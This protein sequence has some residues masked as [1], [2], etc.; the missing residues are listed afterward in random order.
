[1]SNKKLR[2][3]TQK[4]QQR[5]K[6]NKADKEIVLTEP[7]IITNEEKEL[8][9]YGGK[10]YAVG[11][12]V[13]VG[14][15]PYL[16]K[17]KKQY[18]KKTKKSLIP[19]NDDLPADDQN[20]GNDDEGDD[21]NKWQGEYGAEDVAEDL[22]EDENEVGSDEE[23]DEVINPP[24][25]KPKRKKAVR[26]RDIIFEEKKVDILEGEALA[27][28][29][30]MGLPYKKYK[31][32]EKPVEY[33]VVEHDLRYRGYDKFIVAKGSNPDGSVK[34]YLKPYSEATADK[35]KVF[36]GDYL[37]PPVPI[38]VASPV[39]EK[40]NPPEN[41]DGPLRLGDR[42]TFT[43]SEGRTLDME[44]IILKVTDE[45][46]TIV[47]PHTRKIVR[48][49]AYKDAQNLR[50]KPVPEEYIKKG[51][52]K[53][54]DKTYPIDTK[55]IV[56]KDNYL[57]KY[58]S[59][60]PFRYAEFTITQPKV[61]H[62]EG[63]IMD[64]VE[65]GFIISILQKGVSVEAIEV[66]YDN[67]TVKRVGKRAEIKDLQNDKFSAAEDYLHLSI[68]KSTRMD[69][70]KRLFQALA[71]VI[72]DV[73]ESPIDTDERLLKLDPINWSLAN[74][75][76][77][78][79]YEYHRKQFRHYITS[80]MYGDALEKAPSFSEEALEEYEASVDPELII[81]G[82]MHTF[83]DIFDGSAARLLTM[84]NAKAKEDYF[85]ASI[86]D[87]ALRRELTKLSNEELEDT[88]GSRLAG[89]IAHIIA[90]TIKSNPPS[91]P[92]EIE[93]RMKHD[94]AIDYIENY[95]PTKAQIKKFEDEYAKDIKEKYN[96]YEKEWK[97]AKS[98][99]KEYKALRKRIEK[100]YRDRYTIQE[101][102]PRLRL[103]SVDGKQ[104][105]AKGM[106]LAD[107]VSMLEEKL[108][109]ETTTSKANDNKSYL[110]K[111]CRLLI[112]LTPDDTIGKYANFFRSKIQAGMYDVSQLD[113]ATQFHM[114]PEFFTNTDMSDSVFEKGIHEIDL[115]I[116]AEVIDF[117]DIYIL[118]NPPRIREVAFGTNMMWS[119][120]VV[121]P[122]KS[123]GGMRMKI[124]AKYG[125]IQDADNYDCEQEK[126]GKYVCKAK[127]EP[128]TDDDL[129]L[130]YDEELR[131]FTCAS[132]NDVL[133]ALWDEDQGNEPINPMTDKPYGDE[134]M[135]RMRDRYEDLYDARAKTFT[136]RIIKFK[137]T[138]DAILFGEGDEEEVVY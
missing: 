15:G 98:K 60:P 130:C 16:A 30:E 56:S 20:E 59:K 51:Q 134:F 62:L 31:F 24:V 71:E 54:G 10:Y 132:I 133:Y 8:F 112:F 49:V 109:I 68:E 25:L 67:P 1:M 121:S 137:T 38:Y 46:F 37:P 110:S 12:I 27:I 29:K 11:A 119:N 2:K 28:A 87:I 58:A 127:L 4:L 118:N 125:G 75:Q 83:G 90:A 48:D 13:P 3:P 101:S 92:T 108:Y 103:L 18:R 136:K 82:F 5:K 41:Y 19:M 111:M 23:G 45:T 6:A 74:S 100:D 116:D 115:A 76:L 53:I 91:N 128:I 40:R 106:A 55:T 85:R 95:K 114:F 79:K 117:I 63:I 96:A 129:V 120:Y 122:S 36:D 70:T 72:G 33:K 93:L 50:F 64:Y 14:Y 97:I 42:V 9:E 99:K 32:L 84:M 69:A 61:E 80:T 22:A 126:S 78:S 102:V 73:Y 135:K 47:D 43:V 66:S 77:E 124:G 113:A 57:A 52:I 94:W 138:E 104:L 21:E 7:D 123:C 89:M 65:N 17:K 39:K 26:E 107:E 131:K 81:E 86:M 88:T 34:L 105:S 44:G 35:I